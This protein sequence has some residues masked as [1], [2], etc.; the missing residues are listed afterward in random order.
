MTNQIPDPH[1]PNQQG[2][3]Q[4]VQPGAP[5]DQYQQPQGQYQQPQ[6]GQYQQPAAAT[7]DQ[8]ATNVTLNYWLSVF[9]AWIP[10]LIFFFIDRGK[11]PQSDLFH[12]ENLNFSL[13]RTALGVVMMFFG[14]IPYVGWLILILGWLASIVLFVFH[15]IAAIN[16]PERYRKGEA[17]GFIF[18]IPFVR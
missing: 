3:G 16:A 13:V 17:P 14:W 15:L 6:Q 8:L 18:N 2:Q 5:Q 4:P 10:A 9:F 11:S 7:P 12:R 1:D